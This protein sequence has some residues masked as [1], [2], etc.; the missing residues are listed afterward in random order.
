[1]SYFSVTLSG[2]KLYKTIS[3]CQYLI[4]L[5]KRYCQH[6]CY[7]QHTTVI[8]FCISHCLGYQAV[9]TSFVLTIS[10]GITWTRL[11][12]QTFLAPLDMFLQNMRWSLF[13]VPLALSN[14]QSKTVNNCVFIHF[15]PVSP[16]LT[17]STSLHS[18]IKD[19]GLLLRAERVHQFGSQL[20]VRNSA[21]AL[22]TQA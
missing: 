14:D 21:E 11:V 8:C 22:Y 7:Q 6:K 16:I 20:A 17:L 15:H 19:A 3:L 4:Y 10:S 12:C 5:T 2:R 1:M 13:Y 18:L 9:L